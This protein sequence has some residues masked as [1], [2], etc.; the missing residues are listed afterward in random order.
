MPAL[1]SG[2]TP[3]RRS[4]LDG[5]PSQVRLHAPDTAD[6]VAIA[7]PDLL[8]PRYDDLVA[9]VLIDLASVIDDGI[10]EGVVV[11]PE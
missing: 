10:A 11:C 8:G 4:K 5:L 2:T 3:K 6:A 1:K 9:D 7:E